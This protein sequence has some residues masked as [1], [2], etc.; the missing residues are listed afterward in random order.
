MPTDRVVEVVV[1]QEHCPRCNSALPKG[2]V[3]TL[4]PSSL[5]AAMLT[6]AEAV[7]R[8]WM[9]ER[10]QSDVTADAKA[11]A[12]SS[13]KLLPLDWP[14]RA[15]AMAAAIDSARTNVGRALAAVHQHPDYRRPE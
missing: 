6:L 2:V 12:N 4:A 8:L 7:D 3:G 10:V 9:A 15:K 14:A 11:T 5:A 1:K 13:G